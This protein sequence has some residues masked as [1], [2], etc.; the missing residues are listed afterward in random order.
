VRISQVLPLLSSSMTAWS[1]AIPARDE[2]AC[3]S[4]CVQLCESERTPRVLRAFGH[5]HL[6]AL[7]GAA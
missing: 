4:A 3:G 5:G 2:C 7:A 1:A 6:N